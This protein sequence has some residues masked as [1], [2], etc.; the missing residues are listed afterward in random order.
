MRVGAPAIHITRGQ[1][2]EEIKGIGK[3]IFDNAVDIIDEKL[4]PGYALRNPALLAAVVASQTEVYLLTH[5][6]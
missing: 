1:L 5:E 3:K 2:V 6:A 4:G